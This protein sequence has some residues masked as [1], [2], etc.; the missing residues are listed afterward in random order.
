MGQG[1]KATLF[2]PALPLTIYL[3]IGYTV[4]GGDALKL[5]HTMM[6]EELIKKIDDVRFK[7]RFESRAEAIRSLL[8][9]AVEN[10]KGDKNH[11]RNTK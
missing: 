5:L 7:Y 1:C 3:Y 2:L 10:Y 6:P 4:S 9:W 8:S 11:E